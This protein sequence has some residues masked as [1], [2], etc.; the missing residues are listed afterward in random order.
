MRTLLIIIGCLSFFHVQS[1]QDLT[2]YLPSSVT[3]SADIPTPKEVIG[4]E[5][6]EWHVSHDKLIKY[7]ETLANT[8]DRITIKEHG[9]TF[10]NRPILSLTVTSAKNHQILEKIR[11]EHLKLSDPNKSTTMDTENMPLVVYLGYSV[12]GNEPSG[13]NASLLVAYHL[14]AA[15]GDEIDEL[16]NNTIII[17]DPSINP[18]GLNRFASWVNST[19]NTNPVPDGN[20]IEHDEDWPGGRTNHYWFDLNRDWLPAQLPESQARL[21]NYHNWKPNILTDHH[22]MGTNNTFFFQPGIPSRNNPLTPQKNYDLTGEIA[23]YHAKAFDKIGSLYYSKE[24]FDDFYYGK[25][26]TYPDINGSVGILFEQARVEGHV[27]ES[28]NGIITFPFAVRNHF[29]ASLSTLEAGTNLRVDMLNY[30]R[31]FYKSAMTES[32]NDTDKAYVIGSNDQHRLDAFLTMIERHEINFSPITKNINAG[33]KSFKKESSYI[34]PLGQPQYRLIKSIFERR[35]SFQDSLFYDVSAWN[36]GLAFGLDHTALTGKQFQ[37]SLSGATKKVDKTTGL[38][39][40]D[41]AYTLDWS[42]YYSHKA[43]NMLHTKGII[44][45]VALEAFEDNNRTYPRGTILIPVGIQ[46]QSSEQIHGVL[47]TI[48]KLCDV[49]MYSLKSGY[50]SGFNLGSPQF[51]LVRP[52]KILLLVGDGVNSYDAGEVRHLIDYRMS[53]PMSSVNISTFNRANI[54]KYNTIIMVD[55]NYGSLK[56]DKVKN[57]VQSGG[58]IIAMKRAAKW[59]KDKG[60]N[61]ASFK[62]NAKD[63][64]NRQFAYNDR[65]KIRGAQAIGGSIFEAKLDLTHPIGFGYSQDN[66]SVFR[67]GTLFMKKGR[68]PYVNPLVYTENPLQAGYISDENLKLIKSSAVINVSHFGSGRVISFADNPNFRAFWYGTNRLFLN[69]LYFAQ[70]IDKGRTR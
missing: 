57:W 2:Y 19:R 38:A 15:Q 59:L 25:G 70:I 27:Q 16:L 42:Q 50:T 9:R 7:M 44:T 60:I 58:N 48:Q 11:V 51:A 37:P 14:A 49:P 4:H 21:T 54:S 45:K 52:Q 12:H 5:V 35:T 55:G 33:G 68:N 8:S 43:M 69:S 17:L 65:N 32:S 67:R 29:T 13:S 31:K 46:K 18:D 30:Q 6:G 28:D 41:Y 36:L 24:S 56:A 3:Y 40:S 62:K 53:M 64:T 10:E 61:T 47:K 66:I 20:D 22:E 39:K 23:K 63:S 1:Q 26:S 34:I